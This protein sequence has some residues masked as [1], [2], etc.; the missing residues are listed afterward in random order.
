MAM[1]PPMAPIALSPLTFQGV[2]FALDMKNRPT[3]AMKPTAT[4][5]ITVVTTWTE[6]MFLT[7]DR[8]ISGR[9][10]QPD[11]HQQDREP[12][13]VALVD[14]HLDIEHPADRDGS[15]A[16]PRSDPVGPRV[17][18]A[19]GIA[20]GHPGIGVGAA[21]GREPSG[22][23]REQQRQRE[24]PDRRE[25]HRDEGDGSVPSQRGRQ[26]EDADADDAA[27]NE[28][29]RSGKTETPVSSGFRGPFGRQLAPACATTRRHDV[30]AFPGR[31][32][33]RAALFK[34]TEGDL[35]EN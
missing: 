3:M 24:S 13:R 35:S 2:K 17:H 19:D 7:P 23:A 6:P 14:E 25:T 32:A 34:A 4:N 15:V 31:I 28:G 20:V 1:P 11:Q 21:V 30:T 9:H 29:G 18:E 22:Q 12:L 26:V 8:L 5:L 27:H 16:R 33:S 10:P